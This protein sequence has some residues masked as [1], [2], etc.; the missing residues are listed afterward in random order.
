MVFVFQEGAYGPAKAPAKSVENKK[1]GGAGGQPNAFLGAAGDVLM[2]KVDWNSKLDNIHAEISAPNWLNSMLPKIENDSQFKAFCFLINAKETAKDFFGFI[3][4]LSP[5]NPDDVGKDTKN[6]N[7]ADLQKVAVDCISILTNAIREDIK[8]KTGNIEVDISDYKDL[9]LDKYS[10]YN[11]QIV[12]R[13][14]WF[15][16]SR[17]MNE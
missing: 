4:R 15:R 9:I 12:A 16:F 14:V 7:S 2:S 11:E 6:E 8:N 13:A 1:Q 17:Y 10:D 5:F 3:S